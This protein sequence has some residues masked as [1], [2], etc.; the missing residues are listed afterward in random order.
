MPSTYTNSLRLTLQATGENSGTWGN[1]VNTGVTDLIDSSIAGTASITM[2]GADYTLSSNNGGADE[3][4]AMILSLGGSPG[5]SYN[6]IC[7]AVSKLYI[8]LNSTGNSQTLKTSAGTGVSVPN[9][10]AAFL[11]CDG[12]NVVEALSTF[13]TLQVQS[14]SGTTFVGNAQTTP[15]VVAFSAT[16]M[17]VNCALSNVFTTT[18]TA[19]VTTAPTL[20]NPQDGQT[21]NWFLTQD[22]TGSRTM[23]WP[24]SF[25]WP[26]GFV[27]T[28]STAAN[29]V[30]LVTA[31]YRSTTGH[32]YV[33]I[34][35]AFT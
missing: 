34:L 10:K 7:P 25:K 22:A 4:R 35:K 1:L 6:V 26:T 19:N 31:T 8:V 14:Q 28:L 32:W 21:I 15:V 9:G 13:S 5:G 12:T 16:A 17:T 11:R 18:M 3:A 23:T 30:D 20:S 29:S 33:T 24:A 2:T 27:T